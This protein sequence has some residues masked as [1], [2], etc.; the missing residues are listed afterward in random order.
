MSSS[1][2]L[3]RGV[4]WLSEK[5]HKHMTEPTVY[6]R[7]GVSSDPI[8]ATIRQSELGEMA[9][10]EF[11]VDSNR[12]DFIIRSADLVLDGVLV[13]PE[14]GD[15]ISYDNG[16]GAVIYTVRR[17]ETERAYRLVSEF[18]GDMIIHTERKGL[19]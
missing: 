5:R 12:I 11:I 17:D 19:A 1:N 13:L 4:G 18:G 3:K 14:Q 6:K 8:Q 9:V 2:M 16:S 7:G 10:S 15:T